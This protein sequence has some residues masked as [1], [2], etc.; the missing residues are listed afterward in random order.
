MPEAFVEHERRVD[1]ELAAQGR[2]HP[3]ELGGLRDV[4]HAQ[5]VRS[6]I[7]AEADRGERS[8]QAL[9]RAAPGQRADEVLARDGQQQRPAELVQLVQAPQ[10]GDRL[11]RGL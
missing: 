1:L 5:D 4:V 6:R 9:A 8:R 2:S 11:G 10:H 3:Q 7:D